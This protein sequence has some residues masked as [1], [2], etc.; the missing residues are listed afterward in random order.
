MPPC[1]D[2]TAH[3]RGC[4]S[5]PVLA[6]V[7]PHRHG[8]SLASTQCPTWHG[9]PA[10]HRHPVLPQHPRNDRHSPWHGELHCYGHHHTMGTPRSRGCSSP[11]ELPPHAGTPWEVMSW[12][13]ARV[14]G[15]WPAGRCP[16]CVPHLRD[17]G[18]VDEAADNAAERSR[19]LAA[20]RASPWLGEQ[21]QDA[22]DETL[23]A[24]KLWQR[25]G[26]SGDMPTRPLPVPIPLSAAAPGCPAPALGA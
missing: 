6:R 18:E 24:D 25:V 14:P 20:Q 23:H 9:H 11:R 4:A 5:C 7:P 1:R 8:H 19:E 15:M 12:G 10:C 2:G 16:C 3:H 17:H 22:R 26:L 21:V 13:Q